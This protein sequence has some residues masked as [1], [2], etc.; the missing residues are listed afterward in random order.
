[1]RGVNLFEISLQLKGFPMTKARNMLSKGNSKQDIDKLKWDIFKYHQKNN[2]LY[3]N[4]LKNSNIT[5]WHE[6]PIITRNDLNDKRIF[7]PLLRTNELYLSKTSGSSGTPLTYAKDKLS[8]ALTWANVCANYKSL[9]INYGHDLEARFFGIPLEKKSYYTE[10]L[11]DI[12]SNRHRFIVYN[13]TLHDVKKYLTIFE[14]KPFKYLYGYS[15]ALLMFA[16][17]LKKLGVNLKQLCPSLNCCIVTAEV[18]SEEEQVFLK[19]V[20]GVEVYNEYGM[21]EFGQIAIDTPASKWKLNNFDLYIEFLDKNNKPVG[22]N[23]TGNIVITSLYNKAMPFIRYE[24]GDIGQYSSDRLTRLDGRLTDTIYLP[25][26]KSM[27]GLSLYYVTKKLMSAFPEIRENIVR[28]TK[29]DTFE[30][31]FVAD[32][33]LSDALCD[34]AKRAVRDYLNS[35]IT[36]I[37]NKVDTIKRTA[38]GKCKH[39]RSEL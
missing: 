35:D 4:F 30:I 24:V 3:R 10:K 31:D 15:N 18:C 2:P 21:S 39:F 17:H 19:N 11:K 20:L 9:G 37:V 7:C 34:Q 23:K 33:H 6:I 38:N 27:P 1:M 5:S 32:N 29:I 25:D 28:Q 13:L 26:G 14:R 8:H 36:V 22:Q 16:G 12:L